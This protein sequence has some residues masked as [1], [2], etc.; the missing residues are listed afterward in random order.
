ML[1]SDW[2]MY[3][4]RSTLPFN[5][6]FMKFFDAYYKG[7]YSRRQNIFLIKLVVGTQLV[8]ALDNYCVGSPVRDE[9]RVMYSTYKWQR[10]T[11]G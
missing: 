8:V 2:G 1:R 7:T 3:T 10:T 4:P 5:S 6:L 11:S 9:A